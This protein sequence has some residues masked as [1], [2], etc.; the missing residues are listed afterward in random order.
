LQRAKSAA[1]AEA[2]GANKPEKAADKAVQPTQWTWAQLQ[3]VLV[4]EQQRWRKNLAAF[5]G[6][7][8]DVPLLAPGA[9]VLDLQKLFLDVSNGVWLLFLGI[10]FISG[11]KKG[12]EAILRG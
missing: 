8:V 2:K 6:R 5:L 7:P 1:A 12:L 9:P 3:P 10:A 4:P 11:D